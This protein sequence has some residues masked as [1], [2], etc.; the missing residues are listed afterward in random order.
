MEAKDTGGHR[1]ERARNLKVIRG[2]LARLALENS[3]FGSRIE[4]PAK[5]R[6]MVDHCR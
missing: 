2:A 5:S 1:L 3:R 6:T 4:V